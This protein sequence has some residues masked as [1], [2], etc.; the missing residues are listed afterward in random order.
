MM[1]PS[2]HG[3]VISMLVLGDE[4]QRENAHGHLA[5]GNALSVFPVSLSE[6]SEKIVRGQAVITLVPEAESLKK[7]RQTSLRSVL[8]SCNQVFND[9]KAAHGRKRHEYKHGQSAPLSGGLYE[10]NFKMGFLYLPLTFP[11]VCYV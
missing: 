7:K 3:C 6:Q 2:C 5:G 1:V 10:V 9:K 11:I 8:W 4:L